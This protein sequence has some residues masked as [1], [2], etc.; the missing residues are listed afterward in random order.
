LIAEVGDLRSLNWI[1]PD[2]PGRQDD[3]GDSVATSF[4]G[5]SLCISSHSFMALSGESSLYYL[6]FAV[7]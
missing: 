3:R 4:Q 7:L 1:A 2:R 6:Y 5:A